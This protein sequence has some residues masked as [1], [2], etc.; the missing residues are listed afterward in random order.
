MNPSNHKETK[1]SKKWQCTVC[2]LT[3]QTA[4][5]PKTCSKCGAKSDRFIK[6]K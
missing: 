5:P 6:I 1:M 2:G 3:E 4:T